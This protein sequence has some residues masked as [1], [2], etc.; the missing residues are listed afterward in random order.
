MGGGVALTAFY[1]RQ[2][3]CSLRPVIKLLKNL[4]PSSLDADAEDHEI[5][6]SL[7]W[8]CLAVRVLFGRRDEARAP[9]RPLQLVVVRVRLNLLFAGDGAAVPELRCSPSMACSV[10]DFSPTSWLEASAVASLLVLLRGSKRKPRANRRG[11][12]SQLCTSAMDGSCTE[13]GEAQ[14]LCIPVNLRRG[15]SRKQLRKGKGGGRDG[16]SRSINTNCG[17]CKV[18]QHSRPERRE[19][20]R[21]V[22]Q[23]EEL[24]GVQTPTWQC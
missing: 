4:R 24:R 17:P 21:L 20:W 19:M 22:S 11:T 18:N 7:L 2:L 9:T 13:G 15:T 12:M 16:E 10:R 6:Q 14:I 3:L 5:A 23:K 1:N 8:F